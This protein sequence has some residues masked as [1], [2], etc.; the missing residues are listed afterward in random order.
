MRALVVNTGRA[1]PAV[2]TRA[3]GDGVW[4]RGAAALALEIATERALAPEE[5]A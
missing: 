1:A 5:A 4:A 2:E 3:W